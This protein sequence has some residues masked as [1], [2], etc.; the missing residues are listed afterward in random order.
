MDKRNAEGAPGPIR[1]IHK[2]RMQQF[3]FE[4]NDFAFVHFHVGPFFFRG[5]LL[6]VIFSIDRMNGTFFV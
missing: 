1:G 4:E 2:R 6:N 3:G 5:I